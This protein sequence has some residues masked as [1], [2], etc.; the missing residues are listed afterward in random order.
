M[1][2]KIVTILTLVCLLASTQLPALAADGDTA[3]LMAVSKRAQGVRVSSSLTEGHAKAETAPKTPDA[4]GELSFENLSDRMKANYP[5]LQALESA[6]ASVAATDF[7]QMQADMVEGMKDILSAQWLNLAYMN[8]TYT[9]QSLQQAYDALRDSYDDL[10]EGK[11]QR[12]VAEGIRALENTEDQVLM[13]GETLYITLHSLHQQDAQLGRQ[14][15]SLDR[16]VQ[17]MELRYQLGQISALQLQ[18]VKA[19]RTSLAS[20][21]ETLEM[22]I[23]SL[24][25]Q[26]QMMIGVPIRGADS[27]GA[28]GGDGAAAECHGSGKGPGPGQGEQLRPTGRQEYPGRRRG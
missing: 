12:S 17:E 25:M 23:K 22:N 14:L 3:E 18:Q 20:G 16:T 11:L 28:A 24:S 21:R 9:T 2:R 10:R 13:A 5:A 6:I 27:G 8:D 1:K 4:E 7:D 19:G 26:M 15:E